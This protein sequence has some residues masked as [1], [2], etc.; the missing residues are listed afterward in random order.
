MQRWKIVF[1]ATEG[2]IAPTVRWAQ[3]LPLGLAIVGEYP[4]S[5]PDVNPHRAVVKPHA[6]RSVSVDKPGRTMTVVVC[7]LSDK[8]PAPTSPETLQGRDVKVGN[9]TLRCVNAT[10]EAHVTQQELI[11]DAFDDRLLPD[12]VGSLIDPVVEFR[13]TSASPWLFTKKDLAG[14]F[15]PGKFLTRLARRWNDLLVWDPDST[16][17]SRPVGVPLSV[18]ADV[19]DE[20]YECTSAVT[21]SKRDEADRQVAFDEKTR[22]PRMRTCLE[23]DAVVRFTPG[24]WDSVIW[25]QTLM[26]YATW[27]GIGNRT[28]SGLGQVGI[29]QVRRLSDLPHAVVPQ[30]Q[31]W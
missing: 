3:H 27:S 23:V 12:P 20:L 10:L 28:T 29:H 13:V 7:W 17:G 5:S 1:E 22:T 30:W 18:P 31:M 2:R 26:R 24:Q 11:G 16:P 14:E 19:I 21:I 9:S 4:P 15:H 6:V 8:F 25:F